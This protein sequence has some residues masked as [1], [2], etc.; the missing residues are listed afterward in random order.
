[1]KEAELERWLGKQ[2]RRL[3]GLCL[4]WVSPGT[5]GVPD[6]IIILPGGQAWFV[7]LK[8]AGKQP[9]RSQEQVHRMLSARGARVRVVAGSMQA[10]EFIEELKGATPA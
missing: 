7:E 8:Q 2:V 9:T 1:M 4:K 10:A 3:N 6:R 5:V